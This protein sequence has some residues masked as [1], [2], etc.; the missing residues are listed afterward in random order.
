MENLITFKSATENN[1]EKEVKKTK[2]IDA[3]DAKIIRDL[4]YNGRKSF[5]DI[6]NECGESKANIC[7]RYRV[8]E[9]EGIIVGSTIQLDYGYLGYNAVGSIDFR[10]KPE[11]CDNIVNTLRKIPNI[12]FALKYQNDSLVHVVVTLKT[13]DEFNRIKDFIKRFPTVYDIVTNIWTGIRNIPENLQIIEGSRI[14]GDKITIVG[15]PNTV[16]LDNNDK[17]II[18]KLSI[19]GRTPFSIIAKG[20]NIGTNTVINKYN[21]LKDN[22]II[23]TSIQ[24]DPNKLGYKT[25]ASFHVAFNGESSIS[26]VVDKLSQIPDVR[27]IIKTTGKYD[28]AVF[29]L[30][31]DLDQLISQQEEIFKTGEITKIELTLRRPFIRYPGPKEYISTF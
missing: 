28:L 30:A 13:I 29:T 4:L 18:E 7:K 20:L 11:N 16:D 6:A 1:S 17:Q 22:G 24:I 23:K 27:L 15:R 19:N 12:Y 9:K 8:L 2:K 3:I 25:G 5:T 10:I 21:R 14:T 26:V 31:K